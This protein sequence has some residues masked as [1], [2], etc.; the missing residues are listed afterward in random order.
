MVLVANPIYFTL[1]SMNQEESD[2][3]KPDR[4][5]VV[6]SASSTS[7]RLSLSSDEKKR[8]RG[9]DASSQQQHQLEKSLGSSYELSTF[10]VI[11]A[12]GK[13]AREHTGTTIMRTGEI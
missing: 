10:D 9:R 13:E 8:E 12:K 7:P 1:V 2:E 11:C 6:S 4:C 3:K 5:L